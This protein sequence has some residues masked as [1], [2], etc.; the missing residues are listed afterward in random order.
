MNFSSCPSI[1][2]LFCHERGFLVYDSV[3]Y[4]EVCVFMRENMSHKFTIKAT[5]ILQNL[6]MQLLNVLPCIH[7]L[8]LSVQHFCFGLYLNC[9]TLAGLL[10]PRVW[11]YGGNCD[12]VVKSPQQQRNLAFKN[13]NTGKQP[14]PALE[15]NASY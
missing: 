6:L 12:A 3:F 15:R 5:F 13:F 7:P 11:L 1:H 14:G 8:R 9:I 4:T 2:I 10:T